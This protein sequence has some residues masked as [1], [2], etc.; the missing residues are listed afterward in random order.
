[1]G[2]RGKGRYVTI[3]AD[4]AL[5]LEVALVCD[6]DDGERVLILHAQDLLVERAY[7]LERVPRS[8]RVDEQKPFAGPHVLLAHGTNKRRGKSQEK[9]RRK[10]IRRHVADLIRS[11]WRRYVPVFFLAGCIQ[12]IEEGNLVVDDALL[13]VR[14][15]CHARQTLSRERMR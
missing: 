5:K 14:I 10:K 13:P 6:D 8:D 2:E 11:E 15:C 7:F 4:L 3:H 12:N 1:M 9:R